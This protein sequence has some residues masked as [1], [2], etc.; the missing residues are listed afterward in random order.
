MTDTQRDDR[1]VIGSIISAKTA[2]QHE[3]RVRIEVTAI[4][5]QNSSASE[6]VVWGYR[7]SSR[8]RGV[9]STM[10]PRLYIV[11]RGGAA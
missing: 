7:Q 11:T 4:D 8:R 10:F 1:P 6:W 9:R 5:E 2:T 3:Q